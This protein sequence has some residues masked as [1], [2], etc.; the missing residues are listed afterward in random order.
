MVGVEYD[1]AKVQVAKRIAALPSCPKCSFSRRM[2]TISGHAIC[3]DFEVTF[4]LRWKTCAQASVGIDF[5]AGDPRL[6]YLKRTRA[7]TRSRSSGNCGGM[8]SNAS[9]TWAYAMM[10][11]SR[12]IIRVI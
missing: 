10:T 9:S 12:K 6:C 11:C 4:V 1:V 7:R 5:A 3:G 2:L 8:D